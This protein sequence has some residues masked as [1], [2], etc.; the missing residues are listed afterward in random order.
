MLAQFDPVPAEPKAPAAPRVDSVV[1]EANGVVRVR[2]SIPDNGGAEIIGYNVYRKEGA[3]GSYVRLGGG[4]PPTVQS[5]RASFDDVTADP[6][7]QYF[8]KVTAVNSLGESAFCGEFEIGAAG[9]D[10][11]QAR[12][13]LPGK[14]V[15]TDPTGDSAVGQQGTPQHDVQRISIAEPFF[16]DGTQKLVFTIKVANLAVLPPNTTY[17]LFFTAPNGNGYYVGFRTSAP[18]TPATPRFE[19]GTVAIDSITG[20]YGAF[21]Y[22]GNADAESNF[23]P[24]GTITIVV[25]P[26]QFGSPAAETMFTR[27]LL[28]VRIEPGLTPDNCPDDLNPA[29]SYQIKGNA[30]CRPNNAPI[31][32][33]AAKPQSGTAPVTVN[34]DASGSSD[35]DSGDTLATYTFNYGDGTGEVKNVPT[36][37]HIYTDS[38]V[39]RATVRVTDS[40]GRTSTNPAEVV[41]Q[42]GSTLTGV[43]SRKAHGTAGTFDIPL[44]ASGPVGVECRNTGNNT[45]TVV[46]TFQRNLTGVT[47]SS[48]AEGTGNKGVEGIGPDQNQYSSR[49]QRR[50]ERAISHRSPGWRAGYG[51]R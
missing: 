9:P 47:S 15:L 38:G 3:A 26:N 32:A 4:T 13:S 48:I 46:F 33:L 25:P 34:F 51:G 5:D 41:V 43:V 7:L 12:C 1:R 10:D 28:R 50:C 40:R 18:A 42:V 35:P 20:A 45:H 17:P 27:F 2:W 30:F 24:D 14:T 31:A 23:N 44:P 39:Y 21:T 36:A 11:E 29:G 37:S 22:V 19:Y 6:A 8:Y 49:G 16:P